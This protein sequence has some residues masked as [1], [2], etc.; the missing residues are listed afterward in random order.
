M[1]RHIRINCNYNSVES[2]L[3]VWITM[4]MSIG[5]SKGFLFFEIELIIWSRMLLSSF[6]DILSL[7][8]RVWLFSHLR[9]LS[10][11]AF[12]PI[13][14]ISLTETWSF[15]GNETIEIPGFSFRTFDLKGSEKVCCNS[16][17]FVEDVSVLS[18]KFFVARSIFEESNSV[19]NPSM[20]CRLNPFAGRVSTPDSIANI[21]KVLAK[22]ANLLL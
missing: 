18:A 1:L 14:F 2:W 12:V 4:G 15:V 22:N 7:P 5:S 20:S 9:S 10:Q 17:L 13:E 3:W 11:V 19:F 21:I 16:L 8:D 6:T